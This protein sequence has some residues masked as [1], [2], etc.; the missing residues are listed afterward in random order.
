MLAR[1]VYAKN[2]DGGMSV[3][4]A[5]AEL[6]RAPKRKTN[7]RLTPAEEIDLRDMVWFILARE[8]LTTYEIE[9]A[10]KRAAQSERNIRRRLQG[11]A[12]EVE[13]RAE[14]G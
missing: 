8:G 2:E 4:Y 11:F 6:A 10:C 12:P 7:L 9:A 5:K 14:A 1:A 3:D 13:A